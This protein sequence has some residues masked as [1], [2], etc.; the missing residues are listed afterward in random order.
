L[1]CD[2]DAAVI[3]LEFSEYNTLNSQHI[4]PPNTQQ[5]TVGSMIGSDC[6]LPLRQ[7]R[8]LTM[9]GNEFFVTPAAAL[10]QLSVLTSL[11]SVDLT[12]VACAEAIA[13]AADGWGA[14]QMRSLDLSPYSRTRL[15][16]DT[17]LALA[18]VTGLWSLRL[19]SCDLQELQP[20]QLG[21][22]FGQLTSLVS[23]TL[24]NVRLQQQQPQQQQQQ[25]QQ[26]EE[27][28]SDSAEADS[29]EADS[30]EANSSEADSSEANSSEAD[31]ESS[32]SAEDDDESSS[33]DDED[34]NA[35]AAAAAESPLAPLLCSLA[36]R[37]PHM[38]LRALSITGQHVDRA[39]A[40]ALARLVG[41]QALELSSCQLEDCSVIDIVLGLRHRLT[42]FGV[43][44]SRGVTDACLPVLRSMRMLT[45]LNLF[46]TGVTRQGKQRYLPQRLWLNW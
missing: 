11:A 13:S 35:P 34:A 42:E 15:T 27:V 22:V 32:S 24:E 43:P 30:S 19:H 40:A 45:G 8:K 7:L 20:A 21:A 36:A 4:L 28:D 2:H 29:S 6:L 23:L 5:L 46:K 18:S 26:Q 44:G 17:L 10:R 25:Q 31:E 14:V 33:E 3:K 12:Y 39:A 1:P 41:L 16:R 38:Q 37:W 9:L